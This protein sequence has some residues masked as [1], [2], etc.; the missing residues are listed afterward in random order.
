MN[1]SLKVYLYHFIA[2][3][4]SVFVFLWIIAAYL[5]TFTKHNE[6]IATPQLIHLPLKEAVKVIEDKKLRY[7]II[8]S[9]YHP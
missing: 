2:A 4:F 6:Y 1:K 3:V 9:I 8:D 7:I 5:K